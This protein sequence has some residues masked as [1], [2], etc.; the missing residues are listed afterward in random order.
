MIL[1]SPSSF[2]EPFKYPLTWTL[3]LLNIFIF[4][5]IFSG[6]SSTLIT[7]SLLWKPE[8]MLLTGRLYFQYLQTLNST[9]LY[10][11]PEWL[12]KM[13]SDDTDQMEILGSYAL[14]D[15]HFLGKAE[16]LQFIGDEIQINEWRREIHEYLK[17]YRDQLLYRFGLSGMS[18]WPLSWITYQFSHSSWMHLLS[19]L[20]FLIVMGPAVESLVGS[21][22]LLLIYLIGGFAG[23]ACFLLLNSH[24]AVPMVGASAS[25]SALLGFYCLAERRVRVRF[26]YFV[27]PI[28]G[29][30]GSIFLPTLLIIPLFLV[31]DLASVWSS[32]EGLGGGVAHIAHLGGTFLG[33]S[34]GF[35][36]RKLNLADNGL[37]R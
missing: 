34:L 29:Q 7:S 8:G 35:I 15:A 33:L 6:A 26:L 31:V 2:K 24:G 4:L 1:P 30:Y 25:I 17:S 5:I 21:F 36:V 11:R 18:T 28:Q 10:Q 16:S 22:T 13:K 27:S 37:L 14:R 19:N 32:P 3:A 12:L 23:G 9:D 20:V